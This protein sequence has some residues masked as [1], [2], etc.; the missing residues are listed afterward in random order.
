MTKTAQETVPCCYYFYKPART[1]STDSLIY[2]QYLS[3]MSDVNQLFPL[4]LSPDYT[5]S[6]SHTSSIW[7]KPFHSSEIIIILCM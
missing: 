4:S 5:A 2:R 3:F 1:W 6:Y 7:S